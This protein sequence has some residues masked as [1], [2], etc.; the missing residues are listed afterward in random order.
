MR[1]ADS[2]V[3][4]LD[5][6]G[7]GPLAGPVLAAAVILRVPVD[8]LA[9]SKTL[10]LERRRML[11]AELTAHARAGRVSIAVGV[12]SAGEIDRLNIRNASLLAMR[13]ALDRLTIA[14]DRVLVDG[15]VC[16]PAL[17][18]PGEPIIGGDAKVACIAAASI[19]AKVVR[20]RLMGGLDRLWPGYAWSQNAGY[21]TAEHLAALAAFGPTG[22][23]RM[24]FR[25]VREAD[26]LHESTNGTAANARQTTTIA[27]SR[28]RSTPNQRG[29]QPRLTTCRS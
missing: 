23:H 12:A 20:D 28:S 26:A 11:Y 13:R 19:I 2:S 27:V 6:V 21:G 5:E 14:P 3:A 16:P 15:N 25:P 22:Q 8:G 29:A 24:S 10:S 1:I 9:D 4:G 7:R 18:C 17:P